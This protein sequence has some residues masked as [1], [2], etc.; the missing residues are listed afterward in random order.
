MSRSKR[1]VVC[2]RLL[3][4]DAFNYDF[5]HVSSP[6]FSSYESMFA[7]YKSKSVLSL[8]SFEA[9]KP[10]RPNKINQMGEMV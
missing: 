10:T 8:R 1:G 5:F 6:I 4:Y 9:E 7:P 2:E 3:K